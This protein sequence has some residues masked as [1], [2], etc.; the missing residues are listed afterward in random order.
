LILFSHTSLTES[1]GSD[2]D[3]ASGEECYYEWINDKDG[4]QVRRKLEPK[5]SDAYSV[6]ERE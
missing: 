1:N 6:V 3:Y 5:R 4:F 2:A